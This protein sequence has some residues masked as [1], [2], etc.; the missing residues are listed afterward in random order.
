MNKSIF[1][2]LI[3]AS[4]TFPVY[5]AAHG[6]DGQSKF[7]KLDADSNGTISREEFDAHRA[8]MFSKADADANGSLNAEE[9]ERLH[10]LRHAERRAAMHAR[11]MSRLD[12]DGDGEISQAEL[13]VMA[14]KRFS[15]M[16]ADGDGALT[17]DEMR[18]GHHGGMMHKGMGQGGKMHKGMGQGGTP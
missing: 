6:K 12:K 10:D 15:R 18:K 8:S 11:M 17:K 14:E 16:D 5:A 4:I 1:A 9:M 2:A 7:D 3:A 13:N